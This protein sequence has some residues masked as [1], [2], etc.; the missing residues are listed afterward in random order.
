MHLFGARRRA[1]KSFDPLG[2][3]ADP[4][5]LQPFVGEGRVCT[6][7]YAVIDGP[8]VIGLV[9]SVANWIIFLIWPV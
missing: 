8:I 1:S 3:V 9:R 7:C 4:F 2:G 5:G 6:A